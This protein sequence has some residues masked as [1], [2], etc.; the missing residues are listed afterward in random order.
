MEFNSGLKLDKRPTDYILGSSPIVKSI[1]IED[2]DWKKWSPEHELQFNFIKLYDSLMCVTYSA[3]DCIEYQ[4]IFALNNGLISQENAKWLKDNGYFKNGLINF[5]ERFI[6][7]LG[8]TSSQGAY[9]YKIGD[10]IRKFGLIPQDDLPLADTFEEN[11][12]KRF[13]SQANYDKGAEFIKRFP[14]SYEWVGS[15]SEIKEALKY[16]PV[17]VCVKYADYPD[18]NTT[19]VLDPEGSPNHA[20]T[21]VCYNLDYLEIDDSYHRQYKRYAHNKIFSPML[22]TVNFKKYMTNIKIIKDSESASVGIW[23]PALSEE[24][25]KSYCLNFGIT[26]PT[27]PDGGVDWENWIDGELKLKK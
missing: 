17:Q 7:A 4:F 12:D 19:T 9:Q 2:G 27:K 6:G 11:I 16:G 23:L 14:I 18:A 3:T 1:L 25:L 15:I 10:A 5:S 20:V 8:E 13:I 21:G 26:V 24:A 22:Y